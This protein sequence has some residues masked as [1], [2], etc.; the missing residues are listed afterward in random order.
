MTSS[1]TLFAFFC[2]PWIGSALKPAVYWKVHPGLQYRGVSKEISANLEECQAACAKD[3]SFMP[4]F[5]F[6][7]I[8]SN[9]SCQLVYENRKR[10]V[11]AEGYEAFVKCEF[12]G[13]V[14][15]MGICEGMRLKLTC[16]QV[17]LL[18]DLPMIYFSC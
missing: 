3:D 5:A 11:R 13:S 1:L 9:G 15:W 4:C 2:L 16:V 18:V 10:L 17:E 12:C 7:F 8:E 14:W 6:N